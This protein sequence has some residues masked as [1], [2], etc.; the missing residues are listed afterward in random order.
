MLLQVIICDAPNL[1]N[2]GYTRSADMI[3]DVKLVASTRTRPFWWSL[4]SL[5]GSLRGFF[6]R[7]T[8]CTLRARAHCCTHILHAQTKQNT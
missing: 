1:L 8:V 6:M 4:R 5:R 3:C 2:T 7:P